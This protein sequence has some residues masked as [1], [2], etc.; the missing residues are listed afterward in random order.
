MRAWLLIP[1][2]AEQSIA[3]LDFPCWWGKLVDGGSRVFEVQ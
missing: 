1:E 2:S 3:S